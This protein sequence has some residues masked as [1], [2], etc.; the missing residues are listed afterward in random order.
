MSKVFFDTQTAFTDFDTQTA[1]TMFQGVIDQL[2]DKLCPKQT[3]T[4]TYGNK[5]PWLTVAL[6]KSIKDKNRLH[7]EIRCNPNDQQLKRQY[8][9]RHKN[10]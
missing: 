10:I 9:R 3:F 7:V 8:T 6:K 1:F 4:I 2:F 5:L